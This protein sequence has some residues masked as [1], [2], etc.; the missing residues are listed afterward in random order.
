MILKNDA[1]YT[2]LRNTDNLHIGFSTHRN[3]KQQQYI[4]HGC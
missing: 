2:Q 3:I 4:F 1:H